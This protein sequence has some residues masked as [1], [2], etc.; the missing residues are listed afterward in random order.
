MIPLDAFSLNANVRYIDQNCLF[1]QAGPVAS[2]PFTKHLPDAL[3]SSF[4]QTVDAR[5]VLVADKNTCTMSN[6]SS[7]TDA[8]ND[9]SPG[10]NSF[11]NLTARVYQTSFEAV[12]FLSNVIGGCVAKSFRTLNLKCEGP[13]F[14]FSHLP[15]HVSGF[16]LGCLRLKSSAALCK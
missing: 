13:G 1:F 16:D 14:K 15:R 3:Q 10:N 12:A 5:S 2:Y 4:Q 11:V 9:H 6:L 8:K 7:L